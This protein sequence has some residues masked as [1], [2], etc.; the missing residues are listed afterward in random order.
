MIL[1]INF[2][3]TQTLSVVISVVTLGLVIWRGGSFISELT[4]RI[5]DAEEEVKRL[6]QRYTKFKESTERKMDS[7]K[8][9]TRALSENLKSDFLNSIERLHERIISLETKV[10]QDTT[11]LKENLKYLTALISKHDNFIEKIKEDDRNK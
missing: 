6:E 3:I 4:Q 11:F 10:V 9:F 7:E 1:L 8:D 2:G 5:R